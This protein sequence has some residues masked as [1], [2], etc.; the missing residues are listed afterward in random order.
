[1]T[2]ASSDHAK[3]ALSTVASITHLLGTRRCCIGSGRGRTRIAIE[4]TGPYSL[5]L[6]LTLYEAEAVEV[7]VVNP[8]AIKKFADAQMRRSKTDKADAAT[9]C[10]FAR[11]MP[12]VPREPP[13]Q[14]IVELRAIAR[15]I[16]ALTVE[17][18]RERAR[19]HSAQASRTTPRVVANDIEVN[20]RH[21]ERRISDALRR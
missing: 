2:S 1:M 7:M 8:R 12:F 17:H 18:T 14:E 13:A 11:R 3:R 20:L 4:A 6:T 19:L 9:I 16:Q 10:E 15:R 21:L 5:D